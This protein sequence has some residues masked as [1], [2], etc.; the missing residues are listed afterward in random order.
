MR[1]SVK[2]DRVRVKKEEE[3]EKEQ[4]C[5]LVVVMEEGGVEG[6]QIRLAEDLKEIR[7]VGRHR[8]REGI[9]VGCQCKGILGCVRV[10]EGM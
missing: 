3:S 7:G 9:V 10:K 8:K 4:A 5:Y 2:S 6:G 1:A